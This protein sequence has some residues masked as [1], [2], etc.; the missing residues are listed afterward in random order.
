M[1][2]FYNV[3]NCVVIKFALLCAQKGSQYCR[4]RRY[5]SIEPE[6]LDALHRSPVVSLVKGAGSHPVEMKKIRL[7]RPPDAKE[8]RI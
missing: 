6:D 5:E 2:F 3:L 4:K 7:Q 8:G 1:H